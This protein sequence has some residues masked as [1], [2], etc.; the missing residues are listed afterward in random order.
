[1][2]QRTAGV[3]NYHSSLQLGW[4]EVCGWLGGREGQDDPRSQAQSGDD[5][6]PLCLDSLR[7]G[8]EMQGRGAGIWFWRR[9]LIRGGASGR[10]KRKVGDPGGRSVGSHRE[11]TSTLRGPCGLLNMAPTLVWASQSSSGIGSG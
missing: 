4:P 7:R 10:K 8:P 6:S 1:M 5:K 3:E 11:S 9:K 2:R